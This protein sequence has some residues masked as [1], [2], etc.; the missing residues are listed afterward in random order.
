MLIDRSFID[1]KD[2]QDEMQQEKGE[3]GAANE[4]RK[5]HSARKQTRRTSATA[6][7]SGACRWMEQ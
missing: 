4:R 3:R 5:A 6:D 7:C 2:F 1:G